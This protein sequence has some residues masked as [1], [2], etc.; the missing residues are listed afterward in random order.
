MSKEIN[1]FKPLPLVILIKKFSY[2]SSKWWP[3]KI[4]LILYFFAL[5]TSK[6]YLLSLAIDWIF[7][8][9]FL[10]FQVKIFNGIKNL[11]SSFL[12][13]LAS[14]EESFLSLW[15][16]IK[17]LGLRDFLIEYT[18]DKK[19]GFPNMIY[20]NL[21]EDVK[22]EELRYLFTDFKIINWSLWKLVKVPKCRV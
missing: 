11:L 3:T 8:I 14:N 22:D 6:L 21:R 9:G 13:L 12:T 5:P 2:K 4:Y 19:Y 7:F 10:P 18:F 17:Y 1:P 16:I 15:L 20:F